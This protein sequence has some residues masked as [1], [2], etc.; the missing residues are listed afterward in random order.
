MSSGSSSVLRREVLLAQAAAAQ[1][2]WRQRWVMAGLSPQPSD[3]EQAGAMAC[4]SY[5]GAVRRNV[6]WNEPSW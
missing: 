6:Q 4:S 2:E 1:Q 3:V 5:A